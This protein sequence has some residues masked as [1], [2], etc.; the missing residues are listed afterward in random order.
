MIITSFEHRKKLN[1]CIAIS[2]C[3]NNLDLETE[4]KLYLNNNYTP[5]IIHLLRPENETNYKITK[6]RI[7]NFEN[8]L[9]K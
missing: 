3:D 8:I 7:P 1:W 4:I 6:E 9:M 5:E 2:S